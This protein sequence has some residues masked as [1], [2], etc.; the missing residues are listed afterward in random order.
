MPGGKRKN[1]GGV[2][3]LLPGALRRFA[4]ALLNPIVVALRHLTNLLRPANQFSI[5]R[6]VDCYS[7]RHVRNRIV[8]DRRKDYRL[9]GRRGILRFVDKGDQLGNQRV[10]VMGQRLVHA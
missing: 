8:V 6:S 4:G 2:R 10:H 9:N 5:I 1:L 7:V 3:Y